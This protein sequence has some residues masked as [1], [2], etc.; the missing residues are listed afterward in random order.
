[1][2]GAKVPVPFAPLEEHEDKDIFFSFH[3]FRVIES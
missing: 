1:M 2:E 3:E